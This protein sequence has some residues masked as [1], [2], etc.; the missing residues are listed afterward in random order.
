MLN[1]YNS[2]NV[3]YVMTYTSQLQLSQLLN[4]VMINEC[5]APYT[6]MSVDTKYLICILY[7]NDPCNTILF[8]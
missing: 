7:T 6:F 4:I 2:L 1:Y 5:L 3:C 8:F